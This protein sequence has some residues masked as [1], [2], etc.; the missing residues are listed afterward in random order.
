MATKKEGV[1]ATAKDE[2]EDI[3]KP[4]A[5]TDVFGKIIDTY[6]DSP[7]E[8]NENNVKAIVS[9][10]LKEIWNRMPELAKYNVVILY[11]SS[12]LVKQDADSLYS[13]ITKFVDR[14]PI[15]LVLYSR[16]GDAG[17]AYLIGNLLRENSEGNFVISI[18]RYAKSAAT[19]L[20]CAADEIHM[21]SLSELGPIDPQINKMPALGLKNSIATIAQLVQEHPASAP[22]FAEYLKNTVEPIDLG[23]YERVAE[24]AMQYAERLLE[25]HKNKLP[26]SPTSIAQNLVYTYKDH[27][28]V[29]DKTEAIKIFGDKTIKCK[30]KEYEFGNEIYETLNSIKNF[31]DYFGRT[32]Y[33]IGNLDGVAQF[34][35][36]KTA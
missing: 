29:I 36:Q 35:K 30:S 18:P 28:F 34:L 15:L 4:I 22:M 26:S 8:Q 1:E 5:I 24:S 10:Y 21:G 17:S 31:A 3:P 23:Y 11:D 33:Y 9:K 20:C 14:R 16:G 27:G 7:T 32:F 19:L 12:T 13:A 2:T 25:T 6:S